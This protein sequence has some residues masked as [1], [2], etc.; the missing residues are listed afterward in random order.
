MCEGVGFARF[1]IFAAERPANGRDHLR[2]G[3]GCKAT[4]RL[5][6]TGLQTAVKTTGLMINDLVLVSDGEP[7]AGGAASGKGDDAWNARDGS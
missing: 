2:N 5:H 7:N 6:D 1:E 3:D 4:A